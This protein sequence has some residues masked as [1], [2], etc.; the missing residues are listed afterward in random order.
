MSLLNNIFKQKDDQRRADF[1]KA[2]IH[3]EAKIGGELFGPIP[4][5][6]RREFFCLDEHTWV[7]HEEWTDK[8][9]KRQFLMTRYDIRPSG[10]VKSQGRSSYQS[11]SRDELKNFYRA[12]RLYGQKVDAEYS[13]MLGTAA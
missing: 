4:K 11:L 8:S 6:N 9:G 7:W 5:G 12:V 10:V 2:L 1:Y 3:H 13:R